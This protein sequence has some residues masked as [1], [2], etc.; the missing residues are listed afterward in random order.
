[1]QLKN[2]A[3]S[4]KNIQNMNPD[5]KLSHIALLLSRDS[6]AVGDNSVM[7]GEIK[8]LLSNIQFQK[9]AP[10]ETEDV[11]ALKKTMVELR[12]KNIELKKQ[13]KEITEQFLSQVKNPNE[14]QLRL[15]EVTTLNQF[16]KLF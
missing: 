7:L 10:V 1:M 5:D 6:P 2:I 12:R 13:S 9:D 3:V 4:N 16:F 11:S 15:M 8:Q 14:E